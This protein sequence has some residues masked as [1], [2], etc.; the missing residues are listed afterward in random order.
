M[1]ERKPGGM[2]FESWIDKQIREAEER[3]EFD[4]LPGTGKPLTN[5]GRSDDEMW[6]IRQK[7][8]SEGLSTE[9]ALPTPLRLRKELARLPETVRDLRTEQ[10]VRDAVIAL[11]QQIKEHLRAPSGPRIIV[12]L[13][14]VDEIVEGWRAARGVTATPR[15][16]VS[17][18]ATDA[19]VDALPAG[20]RRRRWWRFLRRRAR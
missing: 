12:P 10:A 5:L 11:N 14:D 19:G 13:A 7:M 9:D 3:G 18:D 16:E 15:C 2:S 1:T 8:E 17:S 4:D 6:W 20:E